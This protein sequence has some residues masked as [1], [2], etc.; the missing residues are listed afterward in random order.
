MG[1]D[2]PGIVDN[3]VKRLERLGSRG[4]KFFRFFFL[5]LQSLDRHDDAGGYLVTVIGS[6][7]LDHL[8]PAG[9]LV[10]LWTVFHQFDGGDDIIR[11]V[12]FDS[13]LRVDSANERAM[14]ARA[15]SF[16]AA[17][18]DDDAGSV[19]RQAQ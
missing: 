3:F 18:V 9:E 5:W 8:K 14:A 16:V 1:R 13:D 19:E 12:G 17:M 6:P 10:A 2:C 4:R 15:R 11:G 7:D